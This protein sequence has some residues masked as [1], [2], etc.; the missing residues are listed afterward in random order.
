MFAWS[1]SEIL[2]FVLPPNFYLF[3]STSGFYVRV[4]DFL[5]YV[6]R[7]SARFKNVLISRNINY[8]PLYIYTENRFGKQGSNFIRSRS[9]YFHIKTFGK[10]NRHPEQG[11]RRC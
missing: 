2:S 11:L 7:I 5:E 9:A 8:F 10:P 4:T 6:L 3:Y 1:R